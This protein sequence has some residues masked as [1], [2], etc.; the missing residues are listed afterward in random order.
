MSLY[1]IETWKRYGDGF[2]VYFGLFARMSPLRWTRDGAVR[3]QAAQR[4]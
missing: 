2:G 1:G 4:R 3:A